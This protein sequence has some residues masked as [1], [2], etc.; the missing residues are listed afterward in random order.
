MRERR[1]IKGRVR[2]G[3]VREELGNVVRERKERVRR[4]NDE[5][6]DRKEGMM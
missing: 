1:E 5:D 3:R 4:K 6:I 2:E